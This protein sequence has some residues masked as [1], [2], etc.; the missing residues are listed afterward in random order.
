MNE[1]PEL[2]GQQKAVENYRVFMAWVESKTDSDFRE[3][4]LQGRLNRGEIFASLALAGLFWLKT[5]VLKKRCRNSKTVCG[6]PGF[7]PCEFWSTMSNRSR[8]WLV[9]SFSR[10]PTVSE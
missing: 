6:L 5:L 4:A 7:F 8:F 1:T 3:I 9:G 2:S 10:L